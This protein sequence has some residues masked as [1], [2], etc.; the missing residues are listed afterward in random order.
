MRISR[1]PHPPGRRHL[2]RL[3]LA[4]ELKSRAAG[5]QNDCRA[6]RRVVALRNIDQLAADAQRSGVATRGSNHIPEAP[7][8]ARFGGHPSFAG[9]RLNDKEAPIPAIPV[10]TIEQRAS[11]LCGRTEVI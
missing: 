9:T 10:T 6:G 2:P 4:Q 11:S 8:N 7:A 3:D 1:H 5:G